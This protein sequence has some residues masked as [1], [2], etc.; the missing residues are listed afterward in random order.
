MMKTIISVVMLS[1]FALNS[2][3]STPEWKVVSDKGGVLVKKATVPGTKIVGFRGETSIYASAEKI[4]HVLIDNDHR[5]DWVARLKTSTVL[6]TVGPFEYVIYQEFKLPWPM[7]NR[8]FV[9]RGKATRSEDGRVILELIS[10]NH[11]KGPKTTGV[12][13]ELINSK[14]IITPI[15]KF[16]SKVEVEIFSN[17]KGLI[18]A[19]L[20]NVIQ[21]SWPHKT[22][23]A[24]KTQV[25][26][27]YV[28][29]YPLPAFI[30]K[31]TRNIRK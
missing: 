22:L 6:E 7:K 2:Y 9:Y 21:K 14:Y 11:P 17:P 30:P 15:G 31:V 18:P 4:M 3:A 28:M 10:E 27:K 5:K 19:W 1:L 16:K 29:E 25:E 20:V 12:R 24:I 23:S 8:D 26:K 13:A